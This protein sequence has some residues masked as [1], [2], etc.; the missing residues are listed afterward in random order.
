MDRRKFLTGAAAAALSSF[1]PEAAESAPNVVVLESD[2]NPEELERHKARA[3]SSLTENLPQEKQLNHVREYAKFLMQESQMYV[4]TREEIAD[5]ARKSEDALRA[6]QKS[7]QAEKYGLFIFAD[8][9]SVGNHVQRL[10]AVRE[11]KNGALQFQKGYRVSTGRAGFGN[12]P[13]SGKTPLGLHVI[14]SG[15]RGMLGEIVSIAKTLDEETYVKVRRGGVDHWFVRGF[16]SIPGDDVAEV[17]TDQYLLLGPKT[18]AARG[19]RLHATNRAGK[20][21]ADGSW[22]SYLGGRRRSGGCI[23]MSSTDIRDLYL[24]GYVSLPTKEKKTL[25]QTPIML[26]ATPD[27]IEGADRLTPEDIRELPPR[28]KRPE[29]R[30]ESETV[31]HKEEPRKEIVRKKDPVIGES[32]TQDEIDA[33]P[34][35]RRKQ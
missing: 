32:L 7:V 31:V 17:V 35:R 5:V 16:G 1:G 14:G 3:V 15:K 11:S 20:L 13:D 34:P 9:D 24:S 30:E 6:F 27:A 33:L 12:E 26:H 10:Y 21:E 22:T 2:L 19:I 8:R 29:Q 23:R 4:P 28:R 18:D 25:I